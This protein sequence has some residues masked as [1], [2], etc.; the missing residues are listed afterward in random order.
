MTSSKF[1]AEGKTD[2]EAKKAV[3]RLLGH[4]RE[5]VTRIYLAGVKKDG[6]ADV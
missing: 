5:D 2:S 3:S 1:I 4:E 6:G